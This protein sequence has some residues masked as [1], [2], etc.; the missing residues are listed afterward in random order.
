MQVRPHWSSSKTRFFN[1]IEG[2]F[3][4]ARCLEQKAVDYSLAASACR[5]ANFEC[6]RKVKTSAFLQSENFRF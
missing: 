2:S 3:S 4:K 5:P 6:Q 1:N